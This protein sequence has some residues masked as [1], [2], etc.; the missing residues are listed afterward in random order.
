MTTTTKLRLLVNCGIAIVLLCGVTC[1]FAHAQA[2][3]LPPQILFE[4]L[5]EGEKEVYGAVVL[6]KKQFAEELGNLPPEMQGSLYIAEKIAYPNRIAVNHFVLSYRFV[7]RPLFH[8]W[9][10]FDPYWHGMKERERLG[11]ARNIGIELAKKII[12]RQGVFPTNLR[13]PRFKIRTEL[14]RDAI[15]LKIY[16]VTGTVEWGPRSAKPRSAKW[17]T[18]V[19]H[20]GDT[21]V[22][23]AVYI[24]GKEIWSLPKD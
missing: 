13:Y 22:G 19:I 23:T 2:F 15:D 6:A 12:G 3:Q 11:K 9:T 16:R 18:H 10:G 8:H 7:L 4:L 14:M 1:N 17:T 21:F 24:N 20:N 5:Q